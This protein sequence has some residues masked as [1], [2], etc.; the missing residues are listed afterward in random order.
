MKIKVSDLIAEFLSDHGILH[1]FG[2]VGAANAHI[3][4]SIANRG[5]TQI[6]SVHHEQAGTMAMQTYFRLSGKPTVCLV[7][8]GGGSSNAITGVVSAWMD[9]I[10]GI[11]IS[12]NEN[13][14]YTIDENPLRIWG[15][16]GFDSV[17]MVKKVTKYAKR[18]KDP[19]QI[20]Y[21]LEKAYYISQAE[22][23]GPCWIDVPMS[24]QSAWVEEEDLATFLAPSKSTDPLSLEANIDQII[25]MISESQRPLLWLGHGIRLANAVNLIE[26]LL[27]T[28]NIPALVSW[29]GIDMVDSDHPLVF[30]RAGVYGQRSANF[31]LQNCDLLLALGTRLAIPQVGYDMSE[32][33]RT[34][35]IIVVDVDPAEAQK[36]V[37]RVTLP[38]CEDAGII[39]RSLIDAASRDPIPEKKAWIEQ[40][41]DYRSNYPWIGPEHQDQHGY[42]NSY[43]FMDRLSEYLKPDQVI[44]TDMGT[45]LLSGHQ[46]LRIHKGQR[47]MTSTGLGEM[48]YGLPAAI[49]ASFARSKGEVLCL[50]CD[51]GMMMNLQELQTVVHHQL[52]IKIIIFN[53]DGYLMI[54]HTQKNLFDGRYVAA[55]KESGV[56]CPNFTA[57]AKAFGFPAFQIRSWSDFEEV[58]PD[59]QAHVGPLICEVFM[60][61][62]QYF[63]P[64]LSLATQKDG[65]IVSPPLE[66][67]SPLLP[68]DE[69]RR[70][71][72]IGL[73]PKSEQLDL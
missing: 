26:P 59:I 17:E 53:N 27:K 72:P 35:R 23:P 2:I 13:A 28:L 67:L 52:P 5:F 32:F 19:K 45:A 70:N 73:H 24:I 38:I 37:P 8:A 1:V 16:Q 69:L 18:I 31:I 50:N 11:V 62:E 65:S 58:I 64:K 6:I 43:A 55:T 42:I 68:R 40:C 39:I 51:G 66:D 7:T 61:P 33:A 46:A 56:S 49:G 54:K 63:F 57:L 25:K 71:M 10:P 15:V 44:V 41:D 60:D 20:L 48:G 47:L 14:K 30:G 9:S 22:R 12:G 21:E 3:F 34:A 4:D 29:A 36:H